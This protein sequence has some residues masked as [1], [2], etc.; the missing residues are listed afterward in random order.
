MFK[1]KH[2]VPDEARPSSSRAPV[3]GEG[4]PSSSRAPVLGEGRPS[5]ARAPTRPTFNAEAV[6]SDRKR[7][8]TAY[9]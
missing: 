7:C 6:E 9:R 4:R 1:V 8:K 5:K 3:L 2:S